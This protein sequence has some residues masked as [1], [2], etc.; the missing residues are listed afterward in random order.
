MLEIFHG[1]ISFA[2]G[3]GQHELPLDRGSQVV[4][5]ATLKEAKVEDNLSMF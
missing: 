3:S 1:K 5:V 2:I 4:K